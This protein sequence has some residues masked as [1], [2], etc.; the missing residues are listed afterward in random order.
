MDSYSY[1]IVIRKIL[2][3]QLENVSRETSDWN[4]VWNKMMMDLYSHHIVN[5]KILLEQLR[6]VSRETSFNL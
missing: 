6:N 3:E 2:L 4:F 5:R 1:H